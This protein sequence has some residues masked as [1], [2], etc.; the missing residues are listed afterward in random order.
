MGEHANRLLPKPLPTCTEIPGSITQKIIANPAVAMI[1]KQGRLLGE[2]PS[3]VVQVLNAVQR[4][5]LT[6]DQEF[7]DIVKE[8]R[9][10]ASAY[11]RVNQVVIPRP[12]KD[13]G[14]TIGVGKIFVLFEDLTAARKFQSDTNG[15]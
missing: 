5:D 6:D 12:A 14:Y 15:R 3:K 1:V 2:Q 11:G 13:G 4:S 8:V 9:S 7:H 10:E